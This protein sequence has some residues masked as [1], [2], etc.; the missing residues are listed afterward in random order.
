ME[1]I[2]NAAT[3]NRLK[4]FALHLV[5]A[6]HSKMNVPLLRDLFAA[7]GAFLS[8]EEVGTL[9]DRFADDARATFAEIATD[10]ARPTALRADAIVGLSGSG[11][12]GHHA[13][14]VR[15]A[16]ITTLPCATKRA[17]P[18]VCRRFMTLQRKRSVKPRGFIPSRVC[19]LGPYLI[20]DPSTPVGPSS[21]TR[22]RG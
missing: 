7:N 10:E 13:L 12:T 15:Q 11:V 2:T 4:G 20:R 19:L 8:L 14:L 16:L 9:V 18:G 6:T 17:E 3:P 21:K 22:P 5:P 1:R